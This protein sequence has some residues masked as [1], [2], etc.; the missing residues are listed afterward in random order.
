M[1]K[2]DVLIPIYKHKWEKIN[3]LIDTIFE[4]QYYTNHGPELVQLESKIEEFFHEKSAVLGLSNVDISFLISLV[5]LNV[6]KNIL[7][8]SI[9]PTFAIQAF[10][11]LNINPIFLPVDRHTGLINIDNINS[12]L[13]NKSNVLMVVNLLSLS[14]DYNKLSKLLKSKEIR[15]IILSIDSFGQDYY[16]SNNDF[17][18]IFSLH[19]STIINGSDG[20]L[21]RTNN[22]DLAEKIRNIRSSYGVRKKVNIPFTGNGRMSE[23]QAGLANISFTEIENTINKNQSIFNYFSTNLNSIE[24]I[25]LVNPSLYNVR[26]NYS[27]LILK[28]K[29][30]IKINTNSINHNCKHLDYQIFHLGHLN[31]SINQDDANATE[32]YTN[33]YIIQIP[34]TFNK[35]NIDE[36]CYVLKNHFSN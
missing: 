27:K 1:K 4:R 19:E 15:V 35:K 2:N 20:A 6:K 28:T 13:L 10:N 14:I 36:Y 21:I 9:L 16:K 29:S 3:T 32:F 22:K 30:K 31:Y 17:I 5:S 8:P 26:P 7:V 23:I 11:L 25:Q 24:N 34:S 18:E 33:T 12:E